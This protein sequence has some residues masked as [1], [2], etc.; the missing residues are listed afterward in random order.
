MATD[1]EEM[2]DSEETFDSE[3]ALLKRMPT[4]AKYYNS[5][6]S[7]QKRRKRN[8]KKYR[9]KQAIERNATIAQ[10]CKRMPNDS[11]QSDN[12][13]VQFLNDE[14][15]SI[16]QKFPRMSFFCKDIEDNSYGSLFNQIW[17]K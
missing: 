6:V 8:N 2:V 16:V 5:A 4:V 11:I 12:S 10:R 7:E 14:I 1:G 9:E 3:L 15:L 17:L 13:Y